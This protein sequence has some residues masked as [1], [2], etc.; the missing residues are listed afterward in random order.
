M[1]AGT[2]R[3]QV[4]AWVRGSHEFEG[5]IDFDEV[6]CDPSHPAQLLPKCDAGDHHLVD[7]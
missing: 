1:H 2:E 5:L 4:N 3:Q 6:L 7:D